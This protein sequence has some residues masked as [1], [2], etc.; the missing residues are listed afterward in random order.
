MTQRLYD[1]LFRPGLFLCGLFTLLSI[2]PSVAASPFGQ[3][4]F[5]AD[6]PFGSVTSLSISLGGNVNLSLTPSG[7]IFTGNGSHTI[8]VTSTDVVGY[9]L[10]I[11]GVGTTDMT[12]GLDTI[13][14][15]GNSSAAALATNTWGYNTTGSTTNFVGLTTYPVRFKTATGPYKTGDNTT[16]TYGV[17]A[18]ITKSA[19]SYTGTVTYTAVALTD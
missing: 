11:Y 16:V 3:G 19:G 5:G 15:S 2:A 14:A 17:K 7:S 10:Y 9:E 13:A 12:N 4:V 18:D 6:V 1:R 8:T